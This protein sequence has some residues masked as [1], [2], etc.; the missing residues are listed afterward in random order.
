M[1]RRVGLE[2]LAV[3]ELGQAQV[4]PVGQ[5]RPLLTEGHERLVAPRR[6]TLTWLTTHGPNLAQRH[7]EVLVEG[8]RAA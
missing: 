2:V 4:G 6:G 5:L 8:R 3:E 1:R 7:G